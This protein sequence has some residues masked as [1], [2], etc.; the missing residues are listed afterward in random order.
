MLLVAGCGLIGGAAV[1]PLVRLGA[2]RLVLAE[3]TSPPI[4]SR[5]TAPDT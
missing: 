3:P 5:D 2:E 1:E 4:M